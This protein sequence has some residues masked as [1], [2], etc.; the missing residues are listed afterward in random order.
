MA[1]KI[2]GPILTRKY[3]IELH[4]IY[5]L[6]SYFLYGLLR[7]HVIRNTF[8]QLNECIFNQVRLPSE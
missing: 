5:P 2:G 3:K 4:D 7:M 6:D 8:S 1:W